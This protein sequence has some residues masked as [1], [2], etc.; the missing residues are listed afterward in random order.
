M[1]KMREYVSADDVCSSIMSIRWMTV[2]LVVVGAVI[3]IMGEEN[4][5]VQRP[6]GKHMN[7]TLIMGRTRS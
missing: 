1:Q 4:T 3:H 6:E 7:H 2:V 5:I